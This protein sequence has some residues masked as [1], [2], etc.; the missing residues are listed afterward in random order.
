MIDSIIFLSERLLTGILS[1]SL[2][3]RSAEVPWQTV[4][5]VIRI[6]RLMARIVPV[7]IVWGITVVPSG[8]FEKK[9]RSAL[10]WVNEHPSDAQA[11]GVVEISP[12]FIMI[13]SKHFASFLNLKLNTLN[14]AFARAGFHKRDL[15]V[16]PQWASLAALPGWS[17][18]VRLDGE[19][20]D[21]VK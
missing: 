12:N 2:P 7:Q 14:H 18:R 3:I 1:V 10:D 4:K 20:R 16:P 19:Q 8:R 9:L 13:N 15:K 6:I 17:F 11:I 5:S 21:S